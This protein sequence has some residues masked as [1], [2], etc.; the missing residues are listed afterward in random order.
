MPLTQLLP[1]Q[2]TSTGTG[3]GTR[4]DR[5]IRHC[6]IFRSTFGVQEIKTRAYLY[7]TSVVQLL[8]RASDQ[9][10]TW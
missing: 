3:T 5:G 10:R 1:P 8:D 6:R 2:L 4:V 9:G 7:T